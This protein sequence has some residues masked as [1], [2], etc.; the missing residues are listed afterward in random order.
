MYFC[1]AG[2]ESTRDL[3]RRG[4]TGHWHADRVTWQE[5]KAY[6]TAMGYLR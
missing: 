6:K 4:S 2:K 3:V 1:P 5:E